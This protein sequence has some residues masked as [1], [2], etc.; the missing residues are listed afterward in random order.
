MPISVYTAFNFFYAAGISINSLTLLGMALAIGML[1]DNSVVVMENIYR[2]AS[3][4]VDTDTAVI[5][6]T[7]EVWRS[8]LAATLTTVVVFLPF[9]FSK[10]FFVGI[11]G[12]HIGVSIISTLLVSLVVAMMLVPMVTHVFL[13]F[14][15]KDNE[16]RVLPEFPPHNRLIQI[17][18]V[19]AENLHAKT[20]PDTL[21]VPWAI[22]FV[23]LIIS[24]GLSFINK[25]EPEIIDLTFY[26]TM[27][28]GTT[29]DN[30]DLLVSDVEKRLEKLKEKKDII[31]QIYEEEAEMTIILQ[32]EYKKV[33]NFSF[34]K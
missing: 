1:L 17:Y 28:G 23:T 5:Q 24:L 33:R 8:I 30:T 6:G 10:N 7:T 31:S 19:S 14:R 9:A 18:L 22:F 12:K 13:R 26:I 25:Q 16:W 32:K 11:L 3:Q 27:P 20:C 29:L 34:P 4:G 15:K 21:S 2:L